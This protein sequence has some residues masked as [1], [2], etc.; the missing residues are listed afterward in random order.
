MKAVFRSWIFARENGS[1]QLLGGAVVEA[2]FDIWLRDRP[3]GNMTEGFK[4]A[5]VIVE[6]RCLTITL[7]D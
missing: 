3:D 1:R 5:S 4:V 6:Y 7:N 2:G